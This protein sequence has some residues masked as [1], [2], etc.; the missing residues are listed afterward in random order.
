MKRGILIL[1]LALATILVPGCFDTNVT[2]TVHP[3]WDKNGNGI[4]DVDEANPDEAP[5]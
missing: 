1:A 5:Q 2:Q 4:P 3:P